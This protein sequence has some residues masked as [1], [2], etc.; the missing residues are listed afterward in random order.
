MLPGRKKRSVLHLLY[1]L[2]RYEHPENL[3]TGC[4]RYADRQ[5]NQFAGKIEGASL[6]VSSYNILIRIGVIGLLC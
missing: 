6:L 5:Q 2:W 3:Q 1:Q 4:D